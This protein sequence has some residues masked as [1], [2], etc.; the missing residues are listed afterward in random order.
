MSDESGVAGTA[1]Y[2]QYGDLL[3][4]VLRV[5]RGNE[6]DDERTP[7]TYTLQEVGTNGPRA[8]PG[9]PVAT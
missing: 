8:L 5:L 7:V 4:S 9:E 3:C 1:G 6:H 2:A